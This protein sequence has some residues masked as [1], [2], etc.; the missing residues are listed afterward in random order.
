[1][2]SMLNTT[3]SMNVHVIE[4]NIDY[5][6][7]R[8]NRKESRKLENMDIYR[9]GRN[10]FSQESKRNRTSLVEAFSLGISRGRIPRVRDNIFAPSVRFPDRRDS[11]NSLNLRSP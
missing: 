11:P 3:N 5:P 1:M 7:K 4:S 8:P 2:I 9:P 10:R 6:L